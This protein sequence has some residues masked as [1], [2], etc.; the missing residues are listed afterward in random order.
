MAL[1]ELINHIRFQTD[2]VIAPFLFDD[3]VI[4]GYLQEA[5]IGA[6]RRLPLLIDTQKIGVSIGDYR[7][8]LPNWYGVKSI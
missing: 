7:I 3:A 6:C 5:E 2:D 1:A 4:T 8:S